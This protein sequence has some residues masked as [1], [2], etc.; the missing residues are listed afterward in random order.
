LMVR[1]TLG[2]ESESDDK[3]DGRPDQRVD[4][5]HCDD[6]A[7]EVRLPSPRIQLDTL[8]FQRTPVPV[9]G[10]E[11]GRAR[12][13][14]LTHPIASVVALSP[15]CVNVWNTKAEATRNRLPTWVPAVTTIPW[16][17][18]IVLV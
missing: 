3:P 18:T 16:P 8:E 4:G 11:W 14:I 1:A 13:L 5:C 9:R 15:S 12:L 17:F 6:G 10:T 7:F 2:D